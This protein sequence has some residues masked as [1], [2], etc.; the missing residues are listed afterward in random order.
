MPNF[1]G[2]KFEVYDHGLDSTLVTKDLPIDFLPIRRKVC[3]IEYDSNF[4]AEKPRAF[5]ISLTDFEKGNDSKI[6]RMFENLPPK[7]NESRGCYT[8]NF[9]GRVNKASARNFQLI[10]TDGDDDEEILLSHGKCST[11][12]FNLDYRAP[13]SMMVAFGISLSAI[14]KK[15]VVG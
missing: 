10:E 3:I 12:E 9:Y 8:L 5:R 7:F 14:G 6:L 15:R 1:L 13:F 11:N 4:F 2:T